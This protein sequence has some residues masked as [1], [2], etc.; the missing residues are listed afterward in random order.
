MLQIMRSASKTWVMRG[1]F[2]I[3]VVAFVILWGVGDVWRPGGQSSHRAVTVGKDVISAHDFVKAFHRRKKHY[4]SSGQEPNPNA[5]KQE[6]LD[7]LIFESL[8]NQESKRLGLAVSDKQLREFIKSNPTFKDRSGTFNIDMFK[9]VAGSEGM[10]ESEFTEEIRKQLIRNQL[11]QMLSSGLIVPASYAN[12]LFQYQNEKRVSDWTVVS[13]DKIKNVEAPT[14]EEMT[15]FYEANKAMYTVPEKRDLTVFLIR[16][17]E[18]KKKITLTD[19]EKQQGFERYKDQ[20]KGAIPTKEETDRVINLLKAEKAD[21]QI[22]QMTTQ[23][24]DDIAAGQTLEELA[25]TF[26]LSLIKVEGIGRDGESKSKIEVSPLTLA[27]IVETGFSMESG[28]DA[29][30][31]QLENGDFIA[32]RLDNVHAER[33]QKR[34]E[35]R[36]QVNNAVLAEKKNKLAKERAEDIAKAVNTGIPLKQIAG[37]QGL[38]ITSGITLDRTGNEGEKYPLSIR[39]M[40]FRTDIGKASIA[41]VSEGYAVV[42]PVKTIQASLENRQD[43]IKAFADNLERSMSNDLIEDY[44]YGLSRHYTVEKNKAV[45]QALQE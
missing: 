44:W 37:K 32:L 10:T 13:F 35:V 24:E 9:A 8:L 27:E 1:F 43:E 42:T 30:L 28:D 5:L 23:M 26:N 41:P 39:A 7:L 17:D 2:A 29:N 20:F 14:D 19:E 15:K 18:V 33:E 12:T 34:E 16:A 38:N 21:E 6:V 31:K 22:N 25:K 11:I 4:Q 40:A 3:L 45:L 36:E